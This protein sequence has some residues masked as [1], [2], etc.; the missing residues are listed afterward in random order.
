MTKKVAVSIVLIS[1]FCLWGCG[2]RV[3]GPCLGY[4]CSAR[5]GGAANASNVSPKTT[6]PQASTAS[7]AAPPIPDTRAGK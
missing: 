5:S 6:Q 4:G 1:L 3:T 7:N 2:I